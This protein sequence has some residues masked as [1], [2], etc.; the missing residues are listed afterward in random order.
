MKKHKKMIFTIV[1]LVLVVCL[2][3]LT[4]YGFYVKQTYHPQDPVVTMNIDRLR[5]SKNGAVPEYGARYSQKLYKA[6]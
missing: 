1:A 3:G 5:N 6:Y 4:G 2:L